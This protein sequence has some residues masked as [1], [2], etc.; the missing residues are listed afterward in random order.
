VRGR[1]GLNDSKG[2]CNHSDTGR[3]LH[4]DKREGREWKGEAYLKVS[5]ENT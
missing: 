1:A 4:G 3:D 5:L 2:C